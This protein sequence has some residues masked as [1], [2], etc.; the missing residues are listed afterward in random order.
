[1]SEK[2]VNVDKSDTKYVNPI[3]QDSGT[4]STEK[5]TDPP[6]TPVVRDE[7]KCSQVEWEA[8]EAADR[9]GIVWGPDVSP[10]LVDNQRLRTNLTR[11]DWSSIQREDVLQAL[12]YVTQPY[13]QASYV[14]WLETQAPSSRSYEPLASAD[15]LAAK[16]IATSIELGQ[17]KV[18]IEEM[19]NQLYEAWR[20]KVPSR[21]ADNP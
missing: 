11:D 3:G 2:K 18:E 19:S 6:K 7:D 21:V 5:K 8:L 16:A 15:S 17:A 1:M 9:A 20:R 13:W 4:S 10:N 14:A 12:Q